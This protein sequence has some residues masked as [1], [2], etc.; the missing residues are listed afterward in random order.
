MSA[1]QGTMQSLYLE[2][3][4]EFT[5]IRILTKE[6]REEH[7]AKAHVIQ[8]QLHFEFRYVPL[9]IGHCYLFRTEAEAKEFDKLTN[10]CGR[11]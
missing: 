11:K 3:V 6:Q 8:E 7:N 1:E 4:K 10:A 9:N 5:F 2:Y